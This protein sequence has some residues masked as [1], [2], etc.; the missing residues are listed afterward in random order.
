MKEVIQFFITVFLSIK[1]ST[2]VAVLDVN[3]MMLQPL[4]ECSVFQISQL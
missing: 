4:K 1:I 2:W 3:T